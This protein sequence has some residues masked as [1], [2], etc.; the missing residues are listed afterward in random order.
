MRAIMVFQPTLAAATNYITLFCN[1][2]SD[3]SF[4]EIV[5]CNDHT[6]F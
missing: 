5:F 3:L 6:E 2:T 4:E 1:Q